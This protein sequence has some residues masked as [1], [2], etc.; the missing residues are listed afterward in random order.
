MTT[1]PVT[2]L[3]KRSGNSIMATSNSC[4]PKSMKYNKGGKADPCCMAQ[5]TVKAML[6]NKGKRKK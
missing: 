2:L 6:E 5:P 4:T 1:T 3:S